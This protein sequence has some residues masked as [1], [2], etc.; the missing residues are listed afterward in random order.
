MRGDDAQQPTSQSSCPNIDAAFSIMLPSD[1]ANQ[2]LAK[3]VSGE[4]SP[5]LYP[6]HMPDRRVGCQTVTDCV[7]KLALRMGQ[8]GGLPAE[9][10][11]G[12]D[13]NAG[14]CRVNLL[15]EDGTSIGL[16]VP[17]H[18]V[19]VTPTGQA[20]DP[21]DPRALSANCP[22]VLTSTG[23]VVVERPDAGTITEPVGAP[24]P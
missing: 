10:E 20:V 4:C 23:S 18:N 21:S 16:Q 24:L 9:I 3:S 17:F 1:L 22:A 5:E 7:F 15:L 14:L 13:G 2:S 19:V 8:R 12:L 6:I 11:G